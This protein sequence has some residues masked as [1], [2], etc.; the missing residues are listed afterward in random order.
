MDRIRPS[1]GW[2]AGS[3]PAEGT[4]KSGFTLIELLVVIAIV[5]ILSGIVLASLGNAREKGKV[6]ATLQNQRSLQKAIELYFNDMGFYPPDTSRGWDPGFARALP[7]NPDTG[8]DCAVNAGDCPACPNCPVDWVNQ[9]LANWRGPYIAAW[10]VSTE[11]KGK[12]DYNYWPSGATRYGCTIPAGVYIGVQ[13]DYSDANPIPASAEQSILDKN[14]DSDNCLDGEAQ[15]IL[16]R[17]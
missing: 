10:P 1:E 16:F 11:W 7:Y 14:L 2:D 3:I 8:A 4:T 5:G 15:M 13:R 17:L 6:A 12:Y 9:A